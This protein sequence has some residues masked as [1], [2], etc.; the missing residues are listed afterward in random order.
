VEVTAAQRGLADTSLFIALE[1]AHPRAGTLPA[2]LAVSVVTVG[3]LRLGVLA[4]G[5]DDRSRRLDTLTRALRVEPLPVDEAVA[6]AWASLRLRLR[7][8]GIRMPVVTQD[9][10]YDGVPGVD[11]LRV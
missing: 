10:D 4:A 6:A 11:V 5:D 7:D 9:A 1:T 3:E 8:A 2:S